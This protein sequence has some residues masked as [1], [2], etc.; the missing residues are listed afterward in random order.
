[1]PRT[2]QRTFRQIL[3]DRFSGEAILPFA[4]ITHEALQAPI[5]VVSDACDYTYNGFVF[6]GFPFVMQIL[7]DDERPPRGQIS[8]QNV[9]E[10]IGSS[11][12]SLVTPPILKIE[13][14]ASVDFDS[15]ID[16]TTNT[17]L[18]IS[19]PTPS[20]VADN[21]FLR[22]IAVDSMSATAEIGPYD[23]SVEPWPSIRCTQNKTPALYRR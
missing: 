5:R 11:L 14:L 13:L 8:I 21:L 18:P 6:L 15:A 16:V 10:Q 19:S 7:S 17:R 9:D 20:Y 22:N 4:T 23:V 12:L 1:M 3:E 2:L